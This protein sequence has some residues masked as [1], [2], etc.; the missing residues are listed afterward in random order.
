MI[1]ARLDGEL[2]QRAA[3]EARAELEREI[4]RTGAVN[5]ALDFGRVTF[6]D[7]AGIGM[8]LG[9]YRTVKPLGGRIIVFDASE[10]VTRLLEMAGLDRLII[11]APTLA[12]GMKTME[13]GN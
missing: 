8:I 11:I 1:I 4:K 2:D 3:G 6:M 10:Q 5:I 9:R 7:S 12:E 13:R